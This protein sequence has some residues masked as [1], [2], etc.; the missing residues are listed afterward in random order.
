MAA[1]HVTSPTLGTR[2]R[3]LPA[4]EQ[5]IEKH[6]T[7]ERTPAAKKEAALLNGDESLSAEGARAQ[8]AVTCPTRLPRPPRHEYQQ[9][10][11]TVCTKKTERS[12]A[13]ELERSAQLQAPTVGGE[14]NENKH[15]G[16]KCS[17]RL[18]GWSVAPW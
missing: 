5:E 4:F 18:W 13:I 9:E 16:R 17:K 10:R 7:K 12:T 8:G 14:P 3:W 6:G 2:L 11:V 15:G 1:A